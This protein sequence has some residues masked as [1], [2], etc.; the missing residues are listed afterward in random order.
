MFVVCFLATSSGSAERTKSIRKE[1]TVED[2]A[3]TPVA[4]DVDAE[5]PQ[6]VQVQTKEEKAVVNVEHDSEVGEIQGTNQNYIQ[7][8]EISSRLITTLTFDLL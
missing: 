6:K 4:E 5:K 1:S 2:S 3:Q 8:H 7:T